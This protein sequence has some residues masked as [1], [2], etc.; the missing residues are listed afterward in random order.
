[1]RNLRILVIHEA[2]SG[3]GNTIRIE[4]ILKFLQN[5]GFNV[6]EAV[7]PSITFRYV[8]KEGISKILTHFLPF[9]K[10]RLYNLKNP[11]LLYFNLNLAI[12]VLEWIGRDLDFDAI[13]ATGY[14]ASWLAPDIVKRS[15]ASLIVDV[16]GLA[17][18]EAKGSNDASARIKEILEAEAFKS[19]TQLLVVSNRMKEY[20]ILHFKIPV[21]K[22]SV[23][24]NGADPQELKAKF[25]RPLKVI[26]AGNFAYWE[27][28]D[29]FLEIAKKVSSNDFKFYLAGD[30]S[31]KKHILAR[32]KKEKIPI[33][34][35]GY[36]PRSKM[37]KVLSKMQVGI[38]PSTRDTARL[39]A[40]PI[41]VLDYMS[42][43]LPVIASK[44]GDWGEMIQRENC[45]IPLEED[46][47]EDYLEA[48]E[49]LKNKEIWSEKSRNGIRAIKKKYSWNKTL[50]P[51]T[52]VLIEASKKTSAH[53]DSLPSD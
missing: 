8:K 15:S 11:V 34:Y 20:I 33:K 6:Y 35:L 32:I 37:L 43:G 30:G 4:A 2:T 52:N 22:I 29:D 3:L 12:N 9:R 39:V 45:G 13:L 49:V 48:L 7:L 40:F 25:S 5:S 23:V 18:A 51:V 41:K 47:V 38:A 26:Y 10:F 16:H 1:M 21:D 36:M 53:K 28:V 31:M 19:C 17:G 46:K 24:Y 50:Y 27:K 42:C 14:I 44:V